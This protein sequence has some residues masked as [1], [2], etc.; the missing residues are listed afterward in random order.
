VPAQVVAAIPPSWL[1]ALPW[2]PLRRLAL[3]TLNAAV[4]KSPRAF[5]S[6]T[7]FGFRIAGTTRDLIQRHLY[8]FGVWEPDATAAIRPYLRTGSTVVDVG[9][10]VGYFSLLAATAVGPGGAVHAVEALPSTVDLL[11]RNLALNGTANVVVHPVAVGD[12]PGEVEMFKASESF[13]G[14]SS[15][16]SGEVSEGRVPRVTLDD[17]LAG[18]GGAEVTLL[19][20]DVEGDEESVLRGATRLLG[21]MRPSSAALVELAPPEETG[22]TAGGESV[23]RLMSDFGFTPFVIRN[24]YSARSYADTRVGAPRPLTETPTGWTDGLFVKQ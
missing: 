23:V 1:R 14:S 15:T 22:G 11:R 2:L 12:R 18:V 20:I 6:E 19:K 3:G 8:V 17:L 7:Q 5:E 24:E 4:R 21:Q 13:I 16:H 10:N 9:A